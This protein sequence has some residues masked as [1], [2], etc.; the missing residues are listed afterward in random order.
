MVYCNQCGE[1]NSEDSSEDAGIA[2]NTLEILLEEFVNEYK[3]MRYGETDKVIAYFK[4][5]LDRIGTELRIA[6]DS[7]TN[8]NIEKRVIYSRD[9][10]R[11][12]VALAK[13]KCCDIL[14]KTSLYSWIKK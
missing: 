3:D 12:I 7:L 2:Y 4:A 11:E 8:Y 13:E 14:F 6:E 9:V 1:E 5:E 10:G